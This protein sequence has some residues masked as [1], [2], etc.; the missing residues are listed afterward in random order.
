MINGWDLL[1][2]HPT[3]WRSHLHKCAICGF[4]GVMNESGPCPIEGLAHSAAEQSASSWSSLKAGKYNLLGPEE[5]TAAAAFCCGTVA[6]LISAFFL[7][8]VIQNLIVFPAELHVWLSCANICCH[9]AI[10]AAG[11]AESKSD[12]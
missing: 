4:C 3:C 6:V 7:A 5:A 8:K 12:F 9:P 2:F 1:C 10:T 11:A